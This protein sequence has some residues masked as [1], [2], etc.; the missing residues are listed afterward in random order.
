[1]SPSVASSPIRSTFP[2]PKAGARGSPIPNGGRPASSRARQN[3]T[4]SVLET[5][6]QPRPASSASNKQD[7]NG[8]GTPDLGAAAGVLGRSVPEVK[9]STKESATNSNGEHLLEDVEP[10]ETEMVGGLVVGNRKDSTMKH[11][12]AENNGGEYP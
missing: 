5:T 6:R 12:E 8:T 7:T 10:Q 3:S 4:Q 1:M 11:E 9:A 2:E